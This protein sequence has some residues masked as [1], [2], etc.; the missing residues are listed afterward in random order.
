LL[1]G[2][3]PTRV[4]PQNRKHLERWPHAPFQCCPCALGGVSRDSVVKEKKLER[5]QKGPERNG[6]KN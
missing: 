1:G 3:G 5:W 6:K 2:M 4:V